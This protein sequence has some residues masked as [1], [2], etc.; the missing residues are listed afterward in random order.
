M[1]IATETASEF[2]M[3]ASKAADR[4]NIA[5]ALHYSERGQEL[6]LRPAVEIEAPGV[7]RG[8]SFRVAHLGK[9]LAIKRDQILTQSIVE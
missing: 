5:E 6:L 2:F 8:E 3:L 7:L 1:T 9:V 4:G